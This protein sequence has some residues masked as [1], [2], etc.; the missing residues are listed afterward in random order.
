[1]MRATLPAHVLREISVKASVDPRS[2][3][4]FLE[5]KPQKSMVRSRIEQALSALG[6]DCKG[7]QKPTSSPSSS[8]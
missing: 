6:L 2:V 1:M 7:R 3:R 5:E 4:A 8:R